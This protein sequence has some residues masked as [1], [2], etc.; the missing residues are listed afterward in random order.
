[1]TAKGAGTF[2][3]LVLLY[4]IWKAVRDGNIA[5]AR[6]SAASGGSSGGGCCG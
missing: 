6:R 2:L 5:A 3:V 4:F 1:M